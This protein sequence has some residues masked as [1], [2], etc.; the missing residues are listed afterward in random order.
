MAKAVKKIVEKKVSESEK[1]NVKETGVKKQKITF[2]FDAPYAQNVCVVGAFN[3]WDEN[4]HPLKKD[5]SG[6]WTKSIMIEPGT[7]EYKFVID[8]SWEIDPANSNVVENP[9]GS[10]NNVLRI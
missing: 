7:Y 6:L 1:T 2:S 4:K 10:L 9:F 5:A 8:G 3:D